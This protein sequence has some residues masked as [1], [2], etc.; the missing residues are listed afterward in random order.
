MIYYLYG[1]LLTAIVLTG[2]DVYTGAYYLAAI[3]VV[4]ILLM[5]GCIEMQKK[6][7]LL[8]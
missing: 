7:D 6:I 2:I 5:L 8:S 1:I 3:H 4:C